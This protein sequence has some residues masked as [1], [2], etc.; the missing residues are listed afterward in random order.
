M[1]SISNCSGKC[2]DCIYRNTTCLTWC[3][4]ESVIAPC[5]RGSSDMIH[6]GNGDALKAAYM[7][8]CNSNDSQSKSMS[9]YILKETSNA[10]S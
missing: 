2:F 3:F 10:K 9:Y 7:G 6:L 4:Q 5:Y 1:Y 8:F